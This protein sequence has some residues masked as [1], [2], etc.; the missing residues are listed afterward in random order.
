MLTC[1]VSTN[2]TDPMKVNDELPVHEKKA[3]ETLG[4]CFMTGSQ[5]TSI[6][7]HDAGVP[8]GAH[9]YKLTTYWTQGIRPGTESVITS[10]PA[11]KRED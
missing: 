8:N 7:Q 2:Y 9:D 6:P 10:D 1:E 3:R 4:E 5:T 11:P